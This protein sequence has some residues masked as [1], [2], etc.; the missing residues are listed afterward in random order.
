MMMTPEII[1]LETLTEAQA[2]EIL[3]GMQASIAFL[4][5]ALDTNGDG[6]LDSAEIDAAPDI[7]RALDK[8]GDGGLNETELEGYGLH[9]IP[10]RVRMNAIVRMLDLDGCG[11]RPKTSPL[12]HPA[13]ACSTKTATAL[14]AATTC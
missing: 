4:F 12:P 8:D 11:F 6:R 9:F 14:C 13:F 2:R 7:L 3:Q 1:D 10:G 5:D